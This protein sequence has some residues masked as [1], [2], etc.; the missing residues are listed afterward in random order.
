MNRS[1]VTMP[2]GGVGVAPALRARERDGERRRSSAA[3]RAD[4]D[5]NARTTRRG[6]RSFTLP[7]WFNIAATGAVAAAVAVGVLLQG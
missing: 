5:A 7:T 1:V 3:A 2:G 6:R 4:A